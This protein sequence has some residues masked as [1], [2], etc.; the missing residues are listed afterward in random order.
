MNGMRI[1]CC[2]LAATLLLPFAAMADTVAG[3]VVAISD[4]DTVTVLDSDNRQHKIRLA[5]ID[6]PESHQPFGQ[7]SK[8]NLSALT[9]NRE[10]VAECGKTEVAPFDWTESGRR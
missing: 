1:L 6:A 8:T 10:V 2:L 3:R 7:K 5:G 9:Y 4:G